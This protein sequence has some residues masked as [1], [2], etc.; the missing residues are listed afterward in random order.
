MILGMNNPLSAD[1][2]HALFPHPPGCA[3]HRLWRMLHEVSGC[4][5][6]AYVS[7][8]DRRNLVS[9]YWTKASAAQ[10]ADAFAPPPSGVILVLGQ[11]VARALG[12]APLLLSPQP[13]GGA[14]FRV[15]PHP[16]GRNL[17]YN[18]AEHR[19]VV[20]LLLEELICRSQ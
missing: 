14:T 7:G 13:R 16:S 10:A 11:Q 9:G 17:W 12:L 3:G 1:P 5:K 18:V 4:P 19:V 15:V 20:G 2:R 6:S 8:F